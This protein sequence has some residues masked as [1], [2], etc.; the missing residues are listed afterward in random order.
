MLKKAPLKKQPL[1]SLRLMFQFNLNWKVGNA[2][3]NV[4]CLFLNNSVAKVL[5]YPKAVLRG[6]QVFNVLLQ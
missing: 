5:N 1:M 4:T 6:V 3:L 2:S